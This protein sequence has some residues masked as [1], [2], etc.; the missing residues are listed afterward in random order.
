MVNMKKH[1]FTALFIIVAL[2]VALT[3]PVNSTI[4]EDSPLIHQASVQPTKVLPGDTMT[5]TADVSDPSG[6]ESVTADMGGIE[7][8]TLSLI[9]GSVEHGTWQGEWL[10][11]DTTARDYVTTIAA[12]NSLGKSSATDVVWSDPQTYERYHVKSEGQQTTT[13]TTLQT[14]LTLTFTPNVTGDFLVLAY[15]ILGQSSTSYFTE[16]QVDYMAS[17]L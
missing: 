12:T 3:P 2:G 4:A 10:V 16:W 15:A 1:A 8:I 9:E 11:H 5:V 13:Q 7:T 17:R 6:I 14:A